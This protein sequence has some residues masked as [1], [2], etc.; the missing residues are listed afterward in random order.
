MS[1]FTMLILLNC[2]HFY[3]YVE[4][5]IEEV[6]EK[7]D[8][9][10]CFKSSET[11]Q[12]MV[13]CCYSFIFFPSIT[14]IIDANYAISADLLYYNSYIMIFLLIHFFLFCRGFCR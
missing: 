13:Y 4:P 12:E 9:H 7:R 2:Q 3:S 1:F 6:M 10:I 8:L 11:V 5:R 14:L